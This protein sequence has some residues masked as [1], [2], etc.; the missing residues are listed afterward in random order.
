MNEILECRFMRMLLRGKKYDYDPNYLLAAYTNFR[1][2]LLD[3]S[4]GD[5][6]YKHKF[7]AHYCPVKAGKSVFE[8]VET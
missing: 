1:A 5:L 8:I 2:I 3:V 6:N 4:D 7:R